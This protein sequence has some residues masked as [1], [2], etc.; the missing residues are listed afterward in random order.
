M[1]STTIGAC[2]EGN[3]NYNKVP[4]A[5]P[6]TKVIIHKK[7]IN[8]NHGIFMAKLDGTS[9]QHWNII[10]VIDAVLQVQVRKL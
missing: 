8:K 1:Q 10:D 9:G 4:L 7:S 6:G 2:L 5:P 3:H